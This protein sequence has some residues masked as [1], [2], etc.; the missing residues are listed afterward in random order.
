MLYIYDIYL[1]YLSMLYIYAIYLCC[2][3]PPRCGDPL[4]AGPPSLTQARHRAHLSQCSAALGQY[5]RLRGRDLALAADAARLALCCLG[6]ITGRVAPD[7]VLDLIFRDF[8]IG[9]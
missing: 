8:C 9:K 4:A 6:R 3:P 1:C 5:Q 7:H 2:P